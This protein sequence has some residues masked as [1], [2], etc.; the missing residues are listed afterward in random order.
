M[1]EFKA[2][3]FQTMEATLGNHP[4]RLAVLHYVGINLSTRYDQT[5]NLEFLE[6][7]IILLE[8]AVEETP[9][10]NPDR[11]G[12][13][14]NLGNSLAKRYKRTGDL[15]DLEAAIAR[16]QEAVELT[17]EDHPNR[18]PVLSNLGINLAKRYERTGDPQDLEAAITRSQE[19]VELTPV[20]HPDRAAQLNNLGNNL[21]RRYKRIG[22]LQ[23]LEAAVA[24][25]QEAVELT[26]E[27]HVERPI[28]L[29]NLGNWLRRQY[30]RT[31]DP[32]DLE[33]AITR[34]QEAVELTPEGHP[35]R[36][37]R[38]SNLGGHLHKRYERTGDLQH[39]EAAVA[40]SQEAV[41]LT[42]TD[43]PDRAGWLSN[44]GGHL[45]MR[46]ERTGELQHLEDAV[47][48]SLEAVELTPK[49]HPERAARLNNLGGHLHMRYERAGELQDLEAAV[50]R[51]QE[52]VELT[53]EDHPDRAIRLVNFGAHLARRYERTRDLQD[54]EAAITQ[55]EEAV[56]LTLD[57]HPDRPARLGN[58]G[59]QLHK[60]YERTGELQHLENAIARSQESV[61][62][63][64]ENHPQRA[65]QLN[66]LGNWLRSLYE[67]TGDLH[68][69][70][71]AIA[72]SQEAVNLTPEDHPDRSVRLNNLGNQL[73]SR[74]KRT[75]NVQDL[76]AAINAHVAAWNTNSAPILARLR[77][78]LC[79]AKILVS[80][81]SANSPFVKDWSTTFAF[82]HAAIHLMPLVTARSLEREDQQYIL[83]QLTGL[84][85]LAAA[86][87][88]EAGQSPLEALRLQEL[89]R[90]V[91]NGQ[92]LDY[93]IDIS[94][95]MERHPTLAKAFDSLR[96]ELDS[97]FPPLEPSIP[98]SD[99]SKARRL[100]VQQSAISRRNKIAKDLNNVLVQIRQKPGFENFLLAKS[101]EY[102]LSAARE[103]P[104][105]VLNVTELRSDAILLTKDHV[106]S[107]TL[108]HLSHS[109]MIKYFGKSA[110]TDGYDNEVMRELLEWLWKGAVRPVLQ[111]LG[112]YPT[113]LYPLPRVWWIGVGL[114]AKA[115]IHAAA[116][117]NKGSIKMTTLQY[118]HSSYTSTIRALQFSRSRAQ[119]R[120]QNA[121]MLIV[122]MPTTP[123]AGSL[124]GVIKEADKI[125]HTLCDRAFSA[126]D[127]LEK[128]TA[129]RVLQALPGCNVTHFACHGL[130]SINPADSHLL[131]LKES[132]SHD[133]LCTEEV[134]KL[135]VKDIAALKLPAARLAYL[136]A[137]STANSTL[138]ELVDEVTHIVSSFHIAGF[139]NVIGTLWPAEDEAC[140]KMAVDFYTTFNKTDNVAVSYRHALLGLMKQKPSQ[141][142]Y[143]A[144]FVQFGA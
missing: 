122:T 78:A 119:Q 54:L 131:L 70:D 90:N 57:D 112:F 138:S 69:F 135:R 6:R 123:G 105:V 128:P 114:M 107:I 126:I 43:H 52:A 89:G 98:A 7:A 68:D 22:D 27:N 85:S 101:Q 59:G 125:K 13:L 95:L 58:L 62:L 36:P 104:I 5:G 81:P 31:G 99:M 60:R 28:M 127:V 48:R 73:N 35:G 38:L 132:I 15:Q 44:L 4:D 76:E 94:D 108:P 96:Q 144:P 111:E 1:E 74:Y 12:Q 25:A 53:P 39:L 106:R 64:P 93:R 109:S 87:S 118:C 17:P 20:D 21:G 88:L 55:S 14:S 92:L 23:D 117:Y 91:T 61:D 115:P 41:E 33:A 82:L 37:G 124:A 136:S 29:S 143:W 51:S 63:T 2:A 45:H 3:I 50:A 113:K 116:K 137:C 11:A 18:V 86:V 16:S 47:S 140:R 65:R 8:A 80:S 103:G 134:D 26:P 30:E 40:R 130:S 72:K 100:D 120:Q 142:M 84:A 9:A 141:P 67:R 56:A 139:I 75:G 121:S 42:P 77:A 102:L 97:P 49:D 71:V 46:Y 10:D 24:R 129:E 34:S 83:G 133:G 110:A 32:Q 66:N 79:A 19:A